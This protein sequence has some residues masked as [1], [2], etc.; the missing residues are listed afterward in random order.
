MSTTRKIRAWIFF[1]L[2]TPTF[3]IQAADDS[4]SLVNRG[5]LYRVE[6]DGALV[7]VYGTLHVGHAKY[8]PLQ[9]AVVR[10]LNQSVALALELDTAL[11]SFGRMARTF[12]RLP[13]GHDLTHLL[14][15]ELASAVAK[16]VV[17]SDPRIPY[18]YAL[19]LKPFLAYG[20]IGPRMPTGYSGQFGLESHLRKLAI[21]RRISVLEVEGPR[22]QFETFDDV[23]PALLKQFM[24]DRLDGQKSGKNSAVLADLLR[25]WE[26][27]NELAL[28]ANLETPVSEN[29]E[30]ATM[31]RERMF[32]RRNRGIASFIEALARPGEPAFVA[33]GVLHL[34]GQNGLIALMRTKGFKCSRID[35]ASIEDGPTSSSENAPHDLRQ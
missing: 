5:L 33:V 25:A 34:V 3:A 32:D 2:L 10:A 19:Q 4:Q 6:K 17:E 24:Q 26:S 35:L 7:Y 18:E 27:G 22:R 31:Y 9:A 12:G 28:R 14:G 30:V 15:S 1:F 8:F 21:E 11:P 29:K 16:S 13:P 20:S 23:K